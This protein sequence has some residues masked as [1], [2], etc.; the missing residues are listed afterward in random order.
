MR[1]RLTPNVT[2]AFN[3]AFGTSYTF[4]GLGNACSEWIVIMMVPD[5]L[6]TREQV[7]EAT[8]RLEWLESY[9]PPPKAPKARAP[10]VAKEKVPTE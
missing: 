10:K 1:I 4:D 3:A 7:L 5:C 2:K 8:R 9:R 6:N